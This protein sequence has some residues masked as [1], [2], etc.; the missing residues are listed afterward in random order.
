M[1]RDEEE[2]LAAARRRAA[3]VGF[4]AAGKP[5]LCA[6]CGGKLAGGWCPLCAKPRP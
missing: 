5:I 1:S 3:L 6:W 2:R 4:V